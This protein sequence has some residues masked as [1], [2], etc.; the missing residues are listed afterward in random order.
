[1]NVTDKKTGWIK[2]IYYI[3][4][5]TLIAIAIIVV[6]SHWFL[7]RE[8]ISTIDNFAQNFSK[9]RRSAYG[10]MSDQEVNEL[11]NSTWNPTIGGWDYEDTVGFKESPRKTRFVNVNEFG[12][13]QN[14]SNHIGMDDLNDAIWFF[15]GS[16]TF[17]YGVTDK[18]TIPAKLEN[19]LK[20]R[21]INFGR[22]Y[23]YST[24]ENMLFKDYLKAG[25]RPKMAIFLD[26]VNERCDIE[27]YQDQMKSLFEKASQ[28][29]W[30]LTD[31]VHPVTVISDKLIKR[32]GLINTHRKDGNTHIELH[33]LSCTEYG[34]TQ[35]LTEVLKQN[36]LE[37]QS[38]CA[39]YSID[40][41]TYVQPFAGVHGIHS[42]LKTYTASDRKK[43]QEKFAHLKSTWADSGSIFLTDALDKLN[44]HA[45]VDDCHYSAEASELIAKKIAK[46]LTANSPRNGLLHP[47]QH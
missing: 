14:S 1:M 17:G 42:D 22:G 36:L 9:E 23:F 21:V 32:L 38:L 47:G 35:P 4:A 8:S 24:Q 44:K 6:C 3:V 25:Y 37:R 2:N 12:I 26:G 28:Y 16:T 40:C 13:R 31:T 46:N 18:E 10:H 29:S 5:N 11:L 15:G 41:M 39:L 27:V 20:T 19:I 33:D 7:K 34:K 30:D 45:Y 43:I